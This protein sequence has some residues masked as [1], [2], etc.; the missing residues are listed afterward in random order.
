MNN[1]KPFNLKQVRLLDGHF[2][3]NMLRDRAYLLQLEPDRFLHTFRLTAGLPTDAEPYG[4]WEEPDCQL[5]GHS[6]GHYLSACSMM[7]VATDEKIFKTRVD[8][9]VTELAKCQ[10]ALPSQGYNP[11]FLSAYPESFFDRVD[12]RDSVWAPYYTLHKIMAGLL[13]AY[14]HCDN[15]QALNILEKMAS[16][17]LFRT[18]RLTF[19]QMQISLLNEPGGMTESLADLYEITQKPEHQ[20]L[21]I[22]FND[23]LILNPL[24]NGEDRLDRLHANTQIPKV[25]GAARQYEVTGDARSRTIAE[26]FW[27]RVALA[28]SY[29]TGGH[30]DD[31]LFFP[32]ERFASHLST[33]SAETCNTYNMLKLSRHLFS[34]QPSVQVMDFYERALFNHILG[35]QDPETGMMTYFISHKPGHFKIFNSPENS[36][37]CCT[38]TGME[39][40]VKYGDTIYYHDN[41][42]LY[43]NLFI[44]S[45]LVW[46]EKGLR[47]RQE[48]RFPEADITHLHVSCEQ[49]VQMTLKLRNPA[50]SKTTQISINGQQF[51]GAVEA[52]MYISIDHQWQD[53]DVIDIKL[54]LELRVETLPND[55]AWVA[56]MYGPIVL[57]GAL[58]TEDMPDVLLHDPHSR[59]AEINYLPTPSVPSLT[60]N[61]ETILAAIEP[62][63]DKPLAFVLHDVGLLGDVELI[64]FYRLH[65]QRY[66]I[67]WNVK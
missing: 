13:H 44:A 15:A 38:G 59:A 42:T 31:E 64:P 36:F 56:F 10:D 37:W 17:L 34:W 28:R 52:G 55:S 12:R 5:R 45:E 61:P 53:G 58:G 6:L 29:A 49:P 24:A 41:N 66:T 62:V 35:S 47:L 50:W 65:R 51:D 30:S 40:H 43:V 32:V 20:E 19:E 39:N 11:G 3:E 22:T 18:R 67:Y 4:G 7:Y 23:E 1:V 54:A 33:K 46:A 8:Y 25:L 27:Q 21:L 16:W 14:K 9:M 2:K 57:V 63:A 26:F 60:G 48:T